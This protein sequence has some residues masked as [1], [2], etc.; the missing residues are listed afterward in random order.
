[1]STSI[2]NVYISYISLLLHGRH[3]T[4][5]ALPSLG[6]PPGEGNGNSLQYSCLE[7]PMD[8]GAWWATW[9]DPRGH[10]ELDRA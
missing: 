6:R 5:D 2:N 7:L 4:D 3:Q 10:R 8:R 9:G 1:M